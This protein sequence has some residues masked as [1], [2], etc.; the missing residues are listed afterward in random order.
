MSIPTIKATD[1]SLPRQTGVYHGK[2]RDVY[3]ID[4]KYVILVATDRISAFDVILPKAIPHKGQVLNQVADYFLRTTADVAPNWLM[5]V[6]D[7]NVSLGKKLEPFKVEMVVRGILVGSAWRNYKAGAREICGVALP[8]GM[9][10]Y[11]AFTEPII[12]PTTKADEGHDLDISLEEIVK[13]GL[14]T[15]AELDQLC[16]Y[17]HKLFAK[18]Q[19]MAAARGLLLADTKY[20]FGKSSDGI[21]VIDEVHTPDSS[22]Y[23]Y[24]D[25]YQKFT[26]NRGSKP[27]RQLSKEFVREWLMAHGFQGQKGQA[28]PDMP[29]EFIRQISDRYIEL[30]EQITGQSFEKPS[31]SEDP[32]KR[33]EANIKAAL[34]RLS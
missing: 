7:P 30:Y 1:F 16:D 24:K 8:D 2:V 25:S 17:S 13:Q 6:P 19:E 26:E 11:D 22:R 21:F 9:Q 20:E 4:D 32:L 31:A 33:V 34:G 18:G 14:A 10:E 12:T 29:E 3:T 15:P 5:S 27:P 23:F 28:V